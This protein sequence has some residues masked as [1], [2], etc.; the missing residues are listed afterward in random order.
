M[1]SLN[2][3]F[4]TLQK[5]F[6][7]DGIEMRKRGQRYILPDKERFIDDCNKYRWFELENKYGVSCSILWLWKKKFGMVDGKKHDRLAVYKISKGNDECWECTSHKMGKGYPRG[8]K[9][10]LVR[11]LWCEKNGSWPKSKI[12]RHLCAHAWCINPDH[13]VPGMQFEN[14]VD[15]VLDGEGN[16]NKRSVSLL[17]NALK[18]GII[19]EEKGVVVRVI[20]GKVFD[21]KCSVEIKIVSKFERLQSCM[22]EGGDALLVK[23]A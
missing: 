13:I 18:K 5:Q 17:S 21:I 9:G 14:L 11:R 16:L 22:N 1:K 8:R 7:E 2:I 15:T 10:P 12:V 3:C 23:G 6:K 20:D 19:R 4:R